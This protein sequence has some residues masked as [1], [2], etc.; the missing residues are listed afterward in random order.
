MTCYK[1]RKVKQALLKKGFHSSNSD[2]VVLIYYYNGQKTDIFTKVSF[3]GNHDIDDSL[4]SKMKLQLNLEKGEFCQ[5]VEC[6]LSKEGLK[7]LYE[8]KGIVQ[9]TTLQQS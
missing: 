7:K 3:G 2:H 8:D 6:T 4:I 1:S 5:L 9:R